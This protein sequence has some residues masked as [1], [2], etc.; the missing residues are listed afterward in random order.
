MN[1]TTVQKNGG[2]LTAVVAG[3]FAL[4][5]IFCSVQ[6][7]LTILGKTVPPVIFFGIGLILSITAIYLILR[8][9]MTQFEYVIKKR[10]DGYSGEIME[11]AFGDNAPLDFV[12]YKA[13]RTRLASMEC[14][15]ALSDFV[16]AV[17]LERGVRTKRDVL[18]AYEKEG[19]SYYDYTLTFLAKKTV[20][21]VF[22]DGEKFVGIIIEADNPVADFFVD[23]QKQ[24]DP[25]A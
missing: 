15:L 23:K 20:E 9:R 11:R 18:R 3:L 2:L 12:V 22:A 7:A 1:Y 6:P 14:V 19:F 10:D 25:E 4:A 21:L 16:E 5:V 24:N 17:P 13:M 8:Y